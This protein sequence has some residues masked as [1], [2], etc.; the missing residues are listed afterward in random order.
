M[1]RYHPDLAGAAVPRYTSYPTAVDFTPAVGAERQALALLGVGRDMPVSL[2]IHIPYCHEICWYCG[3]NTGA[4]GRAARL[5]DY[6]EALLAEIATVARLL[7][8]RVG[9]VHFGGGSPNVL[10]PAQLHRIA[11]A[12]RDQFGVDEAAEWAMEIDPRGFDAERAAAVAAIGIRRVSIGV[13]TFALPIQRAINRIQPYDRVAG[14]VDRLRGV[15]IRHINLDLMYGL[16]HQGLDDIA[17][18]IAAALQLRPSRVAMFGYAHVPAMLPR[19]RMIDA[20]TLPDAEA[21]FGQSALADRLMGEAGYRPIGFDH[22]ALACDSLARAAAAGRLRRNFQGFTDDPAEAVI[23]LGASSIS[24]FDGVIVQNEKHVGRYRAAVRDG[25][26]AGV[27]GVVRTAEDRLR[28]AIIAHILCEG[29]VDLAAVCSDHEADLHILDGSVAALDALA[30]RGIV[31]RSGGQVVMAET[32]R[33]YRRL[34][35]AAFD[36][37][38]V[39][40]RGRASVAV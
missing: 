26:L 9:S 34:V 12:I 13:Q 5:D 16:P 31:A 32:D 17:A 18:T 38:R 35:A 30:A 22:Y 6:V 14:V 40:V 15:G 23:G 8:G 33:C 3:C 2:Y 21:R 7:D 29:R 4:I 19:Q 27:R 28:G 20:A 11:D 1:A 36:A 24:Q 39:S 25:R 10:S 37:R